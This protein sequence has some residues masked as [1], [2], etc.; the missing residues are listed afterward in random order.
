MVLED[1][2]KLD[3]ELANRKNHFDLKR[4]KL[5]LAKIAK[6]HAL[7]AAMYKKDQSSMER[8]MI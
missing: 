3:F 8:H 2:T 1:L 7:T 6:F 4:A 5:V